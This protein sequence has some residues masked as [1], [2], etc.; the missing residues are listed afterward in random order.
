MSKKSI[1][2]DEFKD[3]RIYGKE[4]T[5]HHKDLLFWHVKTIIVK[6]TN[7]LHYREFIPVPHVDWMKRKWEKDEKQYDETDLFFEFIKDK[8]YHE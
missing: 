1:I 3:M 8:D 6:F 7:W 4:F 2:T 5:E